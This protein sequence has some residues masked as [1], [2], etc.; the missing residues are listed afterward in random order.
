[1][2]L[3]ST[4][5]IAWLKAHLPS[6]IESKV[7]QPTSR[8]DEPLEID[9]KKKDTFI[10]GKRKPFLSSRDDSDKIKKYIENFNRLY[11]WYQTN[12]EAKPDD[13]KKK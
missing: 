13:Y 11:I 10:I 6:N 2:N 9:G 12:L 5:Q 1:M 4:E 7:L 8:I 3:F